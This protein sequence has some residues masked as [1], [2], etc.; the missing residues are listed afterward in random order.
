MAK[1]PYKTNDR[2]IYRGY[3]KGTIR[4]AVEDFAFVQLDG[5]PRG[6]KHTKATY[7]ELTASTS[8][9]RPRDT[10][11]FY[12]GYC[13]GVHDQSEGTHYCQTLTGN[14]WSIGYRKGWDDSKADTV[15]GVGDE[16]FIECGGKVS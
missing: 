16:A 5:T 12:A 13:E 1:A 10:Y 9:D 14:D 3:R 4:L 7:D 15:R 6:V 8:P 2:V 11:T